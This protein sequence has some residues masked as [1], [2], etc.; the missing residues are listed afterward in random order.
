MSDS[1]PKPRWIS[2]QNLLRV[3]GASLIIQGLL[4]FAFAAPLTEQIFPGAGDEARHVGIIMRQSLASMSFL[5]GLVIFLVRGESDRVARRVLFGCGIGLTAI[6]LS[7]VAYLVTRVLKLPR[8]D[9]AAIEF[10]VIVRN[11]NLGILIKASIF[12]ASVGATAQLGDMVLFTLLL[13][14][15]L[16][17]F[18]GAALIWIYRR[19]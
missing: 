17:L 15:G 12:P 4:F 11:V 14:G 9:S 8:P 13:Y 16:Q 19:Q 5:G 7:M 2:P 1:Q 18:V 3:I 10:E 6:A